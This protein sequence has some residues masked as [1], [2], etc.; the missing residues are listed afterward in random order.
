LAPLLL[1]GT[2]LVPL[3]LA[4]LGAG[5]LGR[6]PWLLV[7][8]PLPALAAA[9]LLGPGAGVELPWL[10][11]GA[12][13][14]LDDTGRVLL[15]VTALVWLVA[16]LFA[17]SGAGLRGRGARA[18]FLLAMAGNLGVV[19][20]QDAATFFTCY[21]LMSFAAYPFVVE[22]GGG[23]ALRAGRVYIALVVV[24]EVL[25]LSGLLATAGAASVGEGVVLAAALLWAGFGI[26]AG[27]VPLHAS[28]PLAYGAAPTAGAIALAGA[29]VNAGLLG[30]LRF[31]PVGEPGIAGLGLVVIAF[32]LVG[33]FW[34]VLAGVNQTDARV[35]LGYSSVSQMGVGVGAGLAIPHA[36]PVLLAA[37]LLY[38][39]HHALAK[40]ALF[41]ALEAGERMPRPIRHLTVLLPALALVGLP[42]TSGA[43]AKAVLKDALPALPAPWADVLALALPLA[44]L[45]TT[46]LMARLLVLAVAAGRAERPGTPAL[47][48]L[49]ILVGAV[50]A[51]PWWLPGLLPAGSVP[52]PAPGAVAL[53]PVA[54]G[55]TL[56]A[57]VYLLDRLARRSLRLPV[58]PGD[59]FLPAERLAS[60]LW[61]RVAPPAQAHHAEAPPAPA[62]TGRLAA[63]LA[64]GERQITRWEL[65]GVALLVLALAI[66][67]ALLAASP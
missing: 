66:A 53:W 9:L 35:L 56:A 38:A 41:A 58:P 43:L 8:A 23:A 31:L 24:G 1:T 32:G 2:V 62:S 25:V 3:A 64:R 46:L 61:Q 26:K 48:G 10:L 45:G 29:M 65:A 47:A 55:V 28:L 52:L 21:A 57:A 17:A 44:T 14:G 27:L 36:W 22:R 11:F 19:V 37:V 18:G 20:A 42:F 7:A 6:A 4:A 5:R 54:L 51:G 15:V 34:G 40:A 16:G 13:L 39:V 59:L 33:A 30:W 50:A 12:R 67:L 49:G 63:L 60:R